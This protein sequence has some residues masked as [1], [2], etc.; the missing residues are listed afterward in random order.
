MTAAG[1]FVR[2]IDEIQYALDEGPCLQAYA[3]QQ[4]VLV[5]NLEREERWPRFTPAALGH[6]GQPPARVDAPGVPEEEE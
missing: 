6:A 3:T 4:M 2:R 5:E 1:D